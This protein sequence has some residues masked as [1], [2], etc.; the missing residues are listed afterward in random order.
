MTKLLQIRW[1]LSNNFGKKFTV[2]CKILGILLILAIQIKRIEDWRFAEPTS[3]VTIFDVSP[4]F[5][6]AKTAISPYFTL[7]VKNRHS[8]FW[9]KNPFKILWNHRKT[10]K[11]ALFFA[12]FHGFFTFFHVFTVFDHFLTV[13]FTFLALKF[14]TK[15]FPN[16]MFGS[17]VRCGQLVKFG[18]SVGRCVKLYRSKTKAL[19]IFNR[20]FLWFLWFFCL[21][22]GEN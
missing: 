2:T 8:R 14:K 13:F 18:A 5:T 7:R 21:C 9:A 16:R 17:D 11:N 6:C 1:L 20:G 22:Y 4:L 12:I 15:Q 19:R 10:S 3:L